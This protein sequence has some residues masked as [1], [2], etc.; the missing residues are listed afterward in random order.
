MIDF[1]ENVSS[2]GGI[3]PREY[4]W[5]IQ[6]FIVVFVALLANYF[7]RRFFDKLEIRF[8]ATRNHWDDLLLDAGRKPAAIFIWVQGLLWALDIVRANSDVD[9]FEVVDPLR[10]ITVVVLLTWFVV[11][12][13]SGLESRLVRPGMLRRPMDVTTAQAIGKL[14]KA[15]SLITAALVLLQS[16][17]FSVAGVLAFGGI[18]GIAIGFAARDLLANFFG[19]LMLYFDRPFAVGD[20]IRSPDREIEGTVEEI[21]WRLTRIRTFD[22]RPL[23]VPNSIFANIAVENP[24][25]MFNRRIFETIGIRYQDADKMAG[26]IQQVH[27]YLKNHPELETDARTLIVNFNTYAASSLDFFIYTFTKTTNWVE[28]HRIKQ[29]VLLKV[30]EIIREAGADIAFPTRTLH[31]ADPVLLETAAPPVSNLPR[32]ES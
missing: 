19:A 26:I 20:W 14:L 7:A 3:I 8:N 18:G 9:L 32:A 2:A 6:V 23:Y 16:L 5:I 30:F 10:R 29:E 17:G 11:R 24:S 25:R 21:G 27:N 13:I 22:Q 31:V 1:L 4:A 15:T 12:F 28:F